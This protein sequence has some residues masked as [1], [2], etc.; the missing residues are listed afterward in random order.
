[1][2]L[3]KILSEKRREFNYSQNQVADLLQVS[4]STYCDWESGQVKPK[5]DNLVKISKLYHIDITDL[6][7]QE[8]SF[9]I[10]NSPHSI[11]L[12]KSPNSKIET[13]EAL[14]KVADSLDK[15]VVL[16]EKLGNKADL[17]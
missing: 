16:I 5:L 6:I 9:N 1:M 4:Q 17:R 3:S 13:P 11:N 14:L 7:D 2:T 8:S 10:L 15:L 12:H